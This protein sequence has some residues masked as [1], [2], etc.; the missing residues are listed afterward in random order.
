M[1]CFDN[2]ICVRLHGGFQADA[3]VHHSQISKT[4]ELDNS[5]PREEK[6]ERIKYLVGEVDFDVWVKI[7]YVAKTDNTF[8]CECSLLMVRLRWSIERVTALTRAPERVELAE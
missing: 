3:L 2:G 7:T 8:K 6:L 1:N 5:L 4:L